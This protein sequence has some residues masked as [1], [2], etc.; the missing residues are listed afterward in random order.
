MFLC[1]ISG[2]SQQTVPHYPRVSSS[3]FL[4]CAHIVLL[5]FLFHFSITYLL[6]LMALGFLSI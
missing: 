3:S 2:Y 4:H 6:F 1:D 5:L